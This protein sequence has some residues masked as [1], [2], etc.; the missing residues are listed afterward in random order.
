M[1]ITPRHML[2][3]SSK[4]NI[5]C[6]YPM[7]ATRI[8]VHNTANDATANNEISYMRTNDLEKSF[9]FAVDDAEVVQGLPL[10]RNGWHAGDGNGKGNRE[11]IG[12][13]ICY[14]KSGGDRFIKA[15]KLA[16]KF[17]AQLL[18]ERGWDISKVTKHQDY[19]GKYCPHRTLDMGWQRFLNM[20]SMEMGGSSPSSSST[21]TT[22]KTYQLVTSLR[23]YYTAA[24]AMSGTNPRNTLVPGTY[25]VFNTSGDA[26]NVSK[27]AG[28]AGSWINSKLNTTSG[29]T[30]STP[31]NSTPTP[32][33]APTPAPVA[34]APDVIYQVRAGNKWF[35]AVKNLEDYAGNGKAITDVAIKVTE[36]AIKY[37]VHINGGKWLPW[38]TGYNIND[39][40]NGYAGNGKAIDAIEV[41]YTTPAGKATKKAKYRVAPVGG[42]YYS[43]QYD[44]EKTGGQDGYA[45]VFGK[46][47]GKLQIVIE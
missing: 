11:G 36:G 22:A 43:W 14:S 3:D 21:S 15:E 8:V 33:P 1:S 2:V 37:R 9:H 46:S 32:T 7:E 44:S 31:T 4:Y 25:Y 40:K 10:D 34:F 35:P 38:V 17:I 45:G 6:P 27:V 24:N 19:S 42:N 30:G 29:N 16:A 12:V 20:V 28:S 5:K 18:K 23:G 47:I 13:E 41:Y 26:V 39:A